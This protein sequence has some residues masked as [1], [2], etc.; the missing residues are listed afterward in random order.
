M[1]TLTRIPPARRLVGTIASPPDKS[2][3][4]RVALAALLSTHTTTIHNYLN[5]GDTLA[6]LSA[7]QSLGAGVSRH[8]S[9]ARITGIGMHSRPQ[10]QNVI[11]ARNSGTL[12]RI[13]LGVL[14][15]YGSFTCLTGDKS[16][17]QRPMGRVLRPLAEMGAEIFARNGERL[18]VVVSGR[19]GGL[20]SGEHRLGVASAQ[21]K[22]ALLFA[23]LFADGKVGVVEPDESR[24]HTERLFEAC[25]IGVE[26]E[27]QRTSVEPVE[28]VSPP[29][30]MRV[31]GDF[32][33][34][35]FW[36]AAALA[37]P[38]SELRITGVGLNPTRTGFLDILS[39][40]GAEIEITS[41]EE[42]EIGEHVGD[43]LVRHSELRGIKV[44][45]SEVPKAVDELP[46]L[47]LLGAFAE[48]ET[49]LEGA[50]ELRVKES[51]RIG[52]LCGEFCRM[53]VEIEER[54]DGFKIHG[55]AGIAGGRVSGVGDHRLAMG[56][57]VAGLASRGGVELEGIEDSS[58][59]YP[60]FARDM[61]RV[62]CW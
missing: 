26:R 13:I 61:G 1:T 43:L 32:S 2:I 27:G 20:R 37:V 56:L 29:A 6:T 30:E 47:A 33:S 5:A 54:E 62:V 38:G 58:V 35:A 49:I 21:V 17:R 28:N 60:G 36:V 44:G 3:S 19:G 11:D 50:E 25:G 46:L 40:M 8:G 57:A 16:L 48:G 53:G 45:A 31:P 14:C 55:G 18:P 39:R 52:E 23:A 15:G 10:P 41:K 34:A 7:L 51:D 59:S 4:H 12:G 9:I 22:S 24:D 42:N